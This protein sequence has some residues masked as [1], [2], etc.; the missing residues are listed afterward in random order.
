MIEKS[1]A[2]F[3]D[4]PVPIGVRFLTTGINRATAEYG[5]AKLVEV[6]RLPAWHADIEEFAH[7]QFWSAN[8]GELVVYIVA[9]EIAGRLAAHSGRV[10][11]AMGFSI[12]TIAVRGCM[13]PDLDGMSTFRRFPKLPRR[14]RLHCPFNYSLCIWPARVAWTPTPAPISRMTS[15]NSPQA[16]S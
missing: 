12:V 14:W 6:T 10:L 13:D 2:V 1:C 15:F 7:S 11:A 9:N 16:G 5:A 3:S 8:P 4:V